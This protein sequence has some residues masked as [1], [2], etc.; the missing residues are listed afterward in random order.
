M[1][2]ITQFA[3]YVIFFFN[4]IISSCALILVIFGIIYF[5]K[6]TAGV[7]IFE[8]IYSLGIISI[9]MG[10]L[11]IFV[12]GFGCCGAL[13]KNTCLLTTYG[14][15][16]IILFIVQCIFG[17]YVALKISDEQ[18]FKSKVKSTIEELFA[19]DTKSFNDLQKKFECCGVNSFIDYN[20]TVGPFPKS[21]CEKE[22]Y[23][24]FYPF[25][26]GCVQAYTD[27]VLQYIQIIGYA[28]IAFGVAELLGA[29]FSFVLRHVHIR[30]KVKFLGR[31]VEETS[32]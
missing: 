20:T 21:C 8:E 2:C 28:A 10:G 7:N 32:I 22:K 3:K 14:F 24:C 15:I 6:E 13:H 4:L 23:P 18:E 27:T 31:P 26:T 16:L 1:S 11:L 25:E 12:A 17:I 19:N 9:C 5:F 29:T 30:N